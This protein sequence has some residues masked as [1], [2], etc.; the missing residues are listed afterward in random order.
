MSSDPGASY[1]V[2]CF[3]GDDENVEQEPRLHEQADEG[4]GEVG[5]DGS[6]EAK[7][8]C[9]ERDE[10]HQPHDYSEGVASGW[11]Y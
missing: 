11:P 9:N 1:R 8:G 6:K 10:A 5:G 7:E 2:D 3:L 4:E